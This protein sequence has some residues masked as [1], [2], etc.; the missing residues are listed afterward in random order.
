MS[1]LSTIIDSQTKYKILTNIELFKEL[2][3]AFDNMDQSRFDRLLLEL[4][5]TTL[6]RYILRETKYTEYDIY[7]YLCTFEIN[8][9]MEKYINLDYEIIDI[10]KQNKKFKAIYN[11]Y[12]NQSFPSTQI[13]TFINH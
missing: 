13:N 10:S 4:T 2:D 1:I 3:L 8:L 9:L 12:N 11:N 6:E 7:H 5:P